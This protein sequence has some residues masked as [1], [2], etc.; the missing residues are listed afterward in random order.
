MKYL[1]ESKSMQPGCITWT[2]DV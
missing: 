2:K 1:A